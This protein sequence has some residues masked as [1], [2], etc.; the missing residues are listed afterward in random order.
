MNQINKETLEQL[1][2][3]IKVK[4]KINCKIIVTS[5][6]TKIDNTYLIKGNKGRNGYYFLNISYE[7]SYNE[8]TKVAFEMNS[9]VYYLEPFKIKGSTA[10]MGA[11]WLLTCLV[12]EKLDKILKAT[13]VQHTGTCMKCGR[14][15]TD[16]ESIEYGMGKTCRDK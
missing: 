1:V 10:I 7:S 2:K 5:K 3:L 12:F 13:D 11:Y 15:L 6:K 9:K 4:E 16:A 8:F 14:E